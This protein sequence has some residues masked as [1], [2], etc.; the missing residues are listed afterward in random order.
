ME[1]EIKEKENGEGKEG[2][3]GKRGRRARNVRED[4]KGKVTA[5]AKKGNARSREGRRAGQRSLTGKTT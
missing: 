3:R 4:I 1:R 2:E 5:E